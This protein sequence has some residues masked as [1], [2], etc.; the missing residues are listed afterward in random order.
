MKR[1]GTKKMNKTIRLVT[2]VITVLCAL[3]VTIHQPVR[4]QTSGVGPTD[5]QQVE[6]FM[7]G[8]MAAALPA[9]H[10]PGA[11]V[12]VV[13][14]GQVL[15]A[16]GYGVADAASQSPVDPQT[17]LIR[18]GSVSKLFTWTAVMQMVE[19][20][21]L[22]LDEDVNTYLDFTIP[23]SYP[24]SITMRHLMSHTAGFEEKANGLF[25]LDAEQV[26]SLEEYVKTNLPARVFRPGT[27]AAYSNYG[28][29]LAGYIVQRISGL[30]FEEY[31]QK[32]ILH[33]LSMQHATFEQPLPPNLAGDMAKGYGYA[34]GQYLQG[35]FEYVVATPAGALSSSGLDMANFM[36]AHLQ[37]G[38]FGTN[39]ILEESTTRQMHS[40]LYT[41][42]ERI[43]GM[44]YGFFHQIERGQVVLSHG[45]DTFLF[46]SN[47]RLLPENNMGIFISTNGSNGGAVVESVVEGFM[48]YYFPK[49]IEIL[50][51]AEGF[52]KRANDYRGN[53]I[54]SRSNFT[55][56]EKIIFSLISSI[57]ITI[58]SDDQVLV[59]YGG[60][61]I[62]YME[63]EP[64]L[65]VNP[66]DPADR[67][68]LKEIDR[69]ITIHT[70][71][72]F[73]FLKS[74]WYHN[75]ALFGLIF[76]GGLI[77]FLVMSVRWIILFFRSQNNTQKQPLSLRF[78]RIAASLF[79]L[80]LLVFL[81]GMVLN[82]SDVNPAY[83]VPNIY[84]GIPAGF[85]FLLNL[86]IVL[87]IAGVIMM[88]L[89]SLSWFKKDGRVSV[90]I[91][92][93]FLTLVSLSNLWALAFWNFLF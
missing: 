56:F 15:F 66:E 85:N 62:R 26:I 46:H 4:A 64:Y 57:N 78:F 24:E 41:A 10:V 42:D 81:T 76:I 22:S 17:T 61:T 58:D 38:S 16:K 93:T 83:G 19:A 30:S 49:E 7:D 90:R 59:T 23:E 63:D 45:G 20:G 91:G 50:T 75:Q 27:I 36:I 3:A 54:M 84:F 44:A 80:I 69:R 89:L 6:A 33:P 87:A 25:K 60:Q 48:D 77:L 37:N 1:S 9:N 8:L 55:S 2:W 12:V 18:P 92:Y 47:L 53:Y 11:V 21:Q 72:P 68:V 13:K 67:L 28:S 86:P 82:F 14:D 5:P 88:G 29:A 39:Q 32:N 34:N 31:V 73:V 74:P 52:E 71:M 43:D 70:H 35:E 40:L 65:L 51:P 79:G